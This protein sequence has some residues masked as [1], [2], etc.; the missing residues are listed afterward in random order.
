MIAELLTFCCL[1]PLAVSDLRLEVGGRVTISDASEGGGGACVSAGLAVS[2]VPEAGLLSAQ[3]AM[4][5]RRQSSPSFG[6]VRV[7]CLALCDGVGCLRVALSRLHVEVV[8][9]ASAEVDPAA[10]RLLR[11]RWPGIIELGDLSA[12]SE[13]IVERLARTFNE[14]A[15]VVVAGAGTPCKDFS[16]LDVDG[17]DFGVSHSSL[18]PPGAESL[19]V[20]QKVVQ[21]ASAALR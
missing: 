5:S 14:V 6:R 1:L 3:G 20:G 4:P 10:R 9:Y 11:Q 13:E 16:A 2:A 21:R 18:A 15:D 17:T 12:I 7:V 19:G 8:G